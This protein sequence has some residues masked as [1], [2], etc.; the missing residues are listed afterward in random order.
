MV[1]WRQRRGSD[2]KT[3]T[4]QSGA[5]SCLKWMF[6]WTICFF[7][8]VLLKRTSHL[9]CDAFVLWSL[10]ATP[11]GNLPDWSLTSPPCL[12][13]PHGLWVI[14]RLLIACDNEVSKVCAA[15]G[16]LHVSGGFLAAASPCRITPAV[17]PRTLLIKGQ[18]EITVAHIHST[19]TI[20]VEMA[21]VTVLRAFR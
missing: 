6:S 14:S 15:F 5:P 7:I 13:P 16:R 1:S 20:K 19:L 10:S 4:C 3:Q 2:G 12:C 11:T 8:K 18:G 21:T 9:L 17:Q